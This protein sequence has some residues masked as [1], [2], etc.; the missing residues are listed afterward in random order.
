MLSESKTQNNLEIVTEVTEGHV[1]GWTHLKG[2]GRTYGLRAYVMDGESIV[3]DR[4]VLG[5]N[6]EGRKY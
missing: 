5:Q 3:T 6:C 1:L 4:H 2:S